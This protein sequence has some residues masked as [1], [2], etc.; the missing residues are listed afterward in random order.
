MKPILTCKQGDNS[1]LFPDIL[2]LYAPWD[3]VVLDMT[4]GNGV[5]WKKVPAGRCHVYP[6]DLDPERGDYHYDFRFLPEDWAG[7]FD[8]VVLDPPYLYTGGFKTLKTS[9]DKGYNNKARAESGIYGVQAVDQLYYDGMTEAKRVLKKKGIL[10]VKCADQVMSGRQVWAH[11]TYGR[12]AEEVLG[13]RREDLFILM[14]KGTPTMRHKPENQ[15]HARRNHSYFL[16][17]RKAKP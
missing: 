1:D 5:F 4:W 12:Y 15:K 6:N 13:F 3:A 14:Q 2:Q 10:V 16:V 9:I 17:F 11:E 7:K 8:L